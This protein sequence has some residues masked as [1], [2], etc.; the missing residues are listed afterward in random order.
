M[1]RDITIHYFKDTNGKA[2]I[3]RNLLKYGK[4]KY[5]NNDIEYKD[6]ATESLKMDLGFLPQLNIGE[7]IYSQ[8][9]AIFYYL[10]KR[11]DSN[12]VGRSEKD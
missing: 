1:D 12:L 11:I 3:I 4:I 6:W 5:K 7:K 9:A 10:A 8:S 2:S